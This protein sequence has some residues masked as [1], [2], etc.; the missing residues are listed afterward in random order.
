MNNKSKNAFLNYGLVIVFFVVFQALLSTGNI[1]SL[2]KGL[3]VPMT[4]YM[5]SL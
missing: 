4:A 5:I 1:S 2:L 3:L